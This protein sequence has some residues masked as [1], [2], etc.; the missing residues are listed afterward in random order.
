MRQQ[1][2]GGSSS[3]RP[4]GMRNGLRVR[5][6]A[7]GGGKE[8]RVKELALVRAPCCHPQTHTRA[9]G[10]GAFGVVRARPE[11]GIQLDRGS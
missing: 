11:R 3:H 5:V 1:R 6:R 2:G 10:C 4:V 8:D 9:R 7:E